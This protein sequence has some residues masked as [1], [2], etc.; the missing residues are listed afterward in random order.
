MVLPPDRSVLQESD[1]VLD[2]VI[3]LLAAQDFLLGD[4]LPPLDQALAE[5]EGWIWARR[6][7]GDHVS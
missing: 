6:P 4:A 2:A 7:K 1:D 3:C 5:R